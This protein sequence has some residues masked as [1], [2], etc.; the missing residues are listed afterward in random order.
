MIDSPIQHRET[1]GAVDRTIN[2]NQSELY[3]VRRKYY[4][5][6]DTVT[7]YCC[8]TRP[9]RHA[10]ILYARI[11]SSDVNSANQTSQI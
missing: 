9:Q 2:H 10:R 1:N 4:N 3:N 7:K 11:I 8:K 6:L 5:I